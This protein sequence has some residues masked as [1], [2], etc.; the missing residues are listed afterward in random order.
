[1][2]RPFVV[3]GEIFEPQAGRPVRL[4][5]DGPTRFVAPA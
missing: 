5:S 3:D 1:M 4:V 2:D